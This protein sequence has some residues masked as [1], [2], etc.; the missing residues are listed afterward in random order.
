MADPLLTERLRM[1]PFETDDAEP[2]Y[3]VLAEPEVGRWVGHD[4]ATLGQVRVLVA[5]NRLHQARHGFALWAVEEREGGAL[6]GEAGLQLLELRGPEVEIGW[7]LAREVWGRGY[8]AEAARAWLDVAFSRLGL[9]QVIA[10]ILPE[11][12]RSHRVAQRLGMTRLPERRH[13][14]DAEHDIYVAL[15]PAGA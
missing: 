6:V 5:R 12:D 4:P 15:N 8:A 14:Y 1:R 7:V 10:T 3:G 13:V 9:P 11:N 2:L